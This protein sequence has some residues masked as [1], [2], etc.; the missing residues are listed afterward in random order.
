MIGLVGDRAGFGQT[1]GIRT[2]IQ[3]LCQRLTR[4]GIPFRILTQELNS[5]DGCSSLVVVGCSSPWAYGIVLK[6]LL[7]RP[8]LP[9]HWIPCYHPPLYVTHQLRARLALWALRRLQRLGANVHAISQ[10]EYAWLNRGHCSV[11]SLPF[12]C[13]SSIHKRNEGAVATL[14]SRTYAL[15]FLGRP[16]AQKGWP[17]FLEIVNQLG[18]PC[19]G[20]IPYPPDGHIPANLTLIVG[21]QDQDVAE[22][23]RESEVLILP[24]DYES[25][26]FA[27]AEAVLSGCC[28]PV[29]GEWPLWLNV[30]ELDWRGLSTAETAQKL[31]ELLCKPEL[32]S[33]LRYIQKQKWNLRPERQAPRLPLLHG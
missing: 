8:R 2:L 18:W 4:E 15:V 12:D 26:G 10:D 30:P 22:G 31:Q 29:L 21:G 20:L 16:V 32:L 23:L 9:V 1:G 13:E 17:A 11:C 7:A 27:Q 28:V 24:S 33:K 5:T 25:F 6:V 3:L 19:L 14:R